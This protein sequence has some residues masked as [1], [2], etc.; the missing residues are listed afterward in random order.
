[1][2]IQFTWSINS[3]TVMP[4]LEDKTD[5]VVTIAW[6]LT[7]VEDAYT[8]KIEGLKH[9]NIFSDS[10][11]PFEDLTELQVINWL[12]DEFG[13]VYVNGLQSS[14][15]SKINELKSPPIKPE[16]KALPWIV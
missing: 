11:T 13:D 8:S 16:Q 7:G 4:V 12:K 5:V 10:F 14:I 15:E 9:F 1:M 2:T 6:T 3:L